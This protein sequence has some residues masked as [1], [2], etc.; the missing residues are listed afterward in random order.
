MSYE[1]KSLQIL[2]G[3]FNMLPPPDK[4][5]QTDYLL[6]QNFR[7]DALGRLISRP[8]YPQVFSLEGASVA[9]SAASAGGPGSPLYVGANIDRTLAGGGVLFYDGSI[10]AR[11]FDGRR[12]GFAS[13]N[14]FMWVMNRGLQGRH[15]PGGAP[16]SGFETWNLAPP[17]ASPTLAAVAPPATVASVT[18]TYLVNPDP[19]F[20]HT[21]TI[22]GV[23]YAWTERDA[24]GRNALVASL[25]AQND[26]NA[27]VT[28][29]GTGNNVVITP[30][31]P[32]TLIAVS[33]SDGNPNTNLSN[34]APGVGTLPDG[35]YQVYL[36]Y[37]N[38]DGSLE[39]NPSPA[40][41]AI[42]VASESILVT[43][44][45]A[46]APTDGRV[47][48]VNIY[49]T[50]GTL[51]SA[52]RVG[53]VISTVAA[54]AT[55][56]V[57]SL[58]D[59]TATNN[60][61]QM[62]IDH[63][64]PPAAAGMIG[65][66]F[67]RLYAWSTAQNKNRLFWTDPNLPQ[68]WP[69]S[70]DPQ[71]GNWVDVGLDDEEL[72]W[73][74][75]HV[76]LL[77][78]YKERSIWMVIGSDPGTA[79]LEQIYDGLGLTGQFALAPAGQIDYFVAP[80]GLNLFDTAQ[81]HAI[82]G[83]VLPLFNQEI[84][85][86][87]PLTPPGN[88]LP[89]SAV[90]SDSTA[91]YGISLGH[92]L[93]RLFV[94]YAENTASGTGYNMLV[95]DE[96]PEPERQAFIQGEAKGRWFYEH[97]AIP[98][99]IGFLGF[100]FD[101]TNM[102]GLT[103]GGFAQGYALSDFRGFLTEDEGSVA[104]ECVYGSHYENCGLPDNDKQWLEIA[105]DYE[106]V[107]GSPVQVYAGFNAG[108]IAPA[109][110]GTLPPGPR[111]TASFEPGSLPAGK[112]GAYLAR[113]MAVLLD[114]QTTG[115]LTIHN[116]FLFFYAEARV[117][118]LASTLPTDLGVGKVKE[119]KELELDIDSSGGAVTVNIVSDLPDNALAIRQTIIVAPAGRAIR[120]FP[121]PTTEGFLWQP[122][123]GG[124]PFRLYSVRLLMRVIGIAVEG[125]ESNAG[126]VWDSMQVALAD[127]EVSTIDQ[128]R[129]EMEASGAC[130]VE[131]FTDLAGEQQTSK[132]VYT[133]TAGARSRGWVTVPVPEGI[134]ARSV[135]VQVTGAGYRIYRAQVRHN[136][137]GRFLI[138]TAPDGLD[139]AFNTLEFDYQTE[140][141]KMYKRIE[142]DMRAD[143]VVNLQVITSQDGDKLAPIYAPALATPN[144][145]E[146]LLVP[147]VPGVRGRL[148]RVR[149][150]GPLP[151]RVYHIRVWARTI[152]DPKAGWEWQD[153]PLEPSQVVPT[154]TDIMGSAAGGAADDTSNTW[155]LVDVPFDVVE[156]G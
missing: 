42:T 120:K 127:G 133:L 1:R 7:S 107:S 41:A 43:I 47:F 22:A 155:Q 86:S 108:N 156:A 105:I 21:L 121:F 20:I 23:V 39:S 93:G 124:G 77:I 110:L 109:L 106:Y 71:E 56:F 29:V 101:G 115:K 4:V 60:G 151:A 24:Q 8:G 140:R 5:P 50:G 103:G 142:I 36:T 63:D 116:V 84:L 114:A 37:Q 143:D 33:G 9:H 13:E 78:I 139:D 72:V 74:S 85:N 128:L 57:Y 95:F 145:R 82:Q 27:S 90:I 113:N 100:F 96:G 144:G 138:G 14:G 126:F 150:S 73:C 136:R 38:A 141:L 18:Y 83:K 61:V 131:V 53:Q 117:A 154:W 122:V 49:A 6:A 12:I 68:Y 132:G 69:G 134:E 111:H 137:V 11:G 129:F 65:P 28:Y 66:H 54:P 97:H 147:L 64:P 112:D 89:G 87:G 102:I 3:G 119:C 15:S 55:S 30:I 125:Y 79:T 99:I 35:T 52:Y 92:A 46:D 75:I 26:S 91:A 34:G 98:N 76:N 32:N 94:S 135:Q 118:A 17:P 123:L 2:G 152:S 59:I 40:S 80:N 70:N 58:P 153:F 146:T 45:A 51:G 19:D 81:V 16:G 104:I 88:V 62:P 10:V 149:L 148:L 44:P 25:L 48:W 31:P 130:S 67:S